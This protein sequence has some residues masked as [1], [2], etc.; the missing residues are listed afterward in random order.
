L[1]A[2]KKAP[3]GVGSETFEEQPQEQRRKLQE[4][5]GQYTE[6]AG[7]P[8]MEANEL[9]GT[10]AEILAQTAQPTVVP[11][12]EF[13]HAEAQKGPMAVAASMEMPKHAE[14]GPAG[15]TEPVEPTGKGQAEAKEISAQGAE[16]AAREK[17]LGEEP[18]FT[19]LEVQ[20]NLA[21]DVL[22]EPKKRADEA[23]TQAVAS[24]EFASLLLRRREREVETSASEA[25]IAKPLTMRKERACCC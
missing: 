3:G 4:G 5:W 15:G 14:S 16:E 8:N 22:V 21:E 10:E 17:V 23:W 1:S 18:L 19:N 20:A 13:W 12:E 7:P 9:V 25:S 2:T 6:T 24:K 11:W